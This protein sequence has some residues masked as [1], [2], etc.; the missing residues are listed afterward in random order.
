[1]TDLFVF[2][3][4]L[5]N[6]LFLFRIHFL[7]FSMKLL[8]YF[9]T[10]CSNFSFSWLFELKFW[11]ISLPPIIFSKLKESIF[12]DLISLL[13]KFYS[14]EIILNL[15][16]LVKQ[17]MREGIQTSFSR[18]RAFSVKDLMIGLPYFSLLFCSFCWVTNL[19]SSVLSG[20]SSF[21]SLTIAVGRFRVGISE[22][23]FL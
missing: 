19:I 20:M 7:V 5:S 16:I 14:L 18:R 23:F 21:P 2:S 1:M 12:R 6:C 10:F 13:T 8:L 11:N 9:C 17:R 15:S 4:S 22:V 3:I